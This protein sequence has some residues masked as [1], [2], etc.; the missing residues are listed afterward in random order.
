MST[1]ESCTQHEDVDDFYKN[2]KEVGT[3]Q[4]EMMTIFDQLCRRVALLG[5]ELAK[6]Y[7]RESRSALS[8]GTH[9]DNFFNGFVFDMNSKNLF[10]LIDVGEIHSDSTIKTTRA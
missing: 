5:A 7:A 1:H 3:V 10:A 4:R 8:Q 2:L 6:S 9:S